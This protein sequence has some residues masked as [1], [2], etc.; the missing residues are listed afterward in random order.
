MAIPRLTTWLTSGFETLA[1]LAPQ[2]PQDARF[3]RSQLPITPEKATASWGHFG[4]TV[5]NYTGVINA[6]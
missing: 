2:P 6:G 1:A 4:D 5:E 3:A